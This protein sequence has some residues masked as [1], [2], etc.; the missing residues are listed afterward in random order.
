MQSLIYGIGPDGKTA[1][2]VKVNA[3]G[4]LVVGGVGGGAASADR[5]VVTGLYSVKTAGTGY[6]IGDALACTRVLD[7]SGA[8]PSQVGS[9][10]WYNE[11][12]G[13]V[14]GAAPS[15][16]HLTLVGSSALT[17]VQL[18]ASA[19]AVT[20]A[21]L[22]ASLGA[23]TSAQ[24]TSVVPASDASFA[25]APTGYMSAAAVSRPANTTAYAAGDVVGGALTF[26]AAGPTAGH[27]VLTSC[28]LRYDVAAAPS[29]MATFRLY[30]YSSSPPSAYADNAAWDLP[31][32]DRSAFLGYIDFGSI[33]DLGATLFA[34]VDQV[35]KQ[36]KL[37]AAE[38]ALYGYLVTASGYTPAA[39]SET[40]Q[41]TLR[42]VGV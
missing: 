13:A 21:Q 34:Q 22:P 14:L 5:E 36:V 29:G 32:G 25:V 28:D 4:E 3:S 35:N 30:L 12:T 2:P 33:V 37:G 1:V 42:T 38:T 16:A 10:V 24:S 15:A 9:A 41:V 8:T 39:S 27:V 23:K 11:T 7:V 18:R 19:V 26:S 40:F 6:S 20:S 31:S 17:D